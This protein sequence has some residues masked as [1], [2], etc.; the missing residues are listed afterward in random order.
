M[1]IVMFSVLTDIMYYTFILIPFW[2]HSMYN[3]KAEKPGAP[4]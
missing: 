3:S 1:P 2:R 4:V